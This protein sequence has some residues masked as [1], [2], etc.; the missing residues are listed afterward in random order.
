MEHSWIFLCTPPG[1]LSTRGWIRRV[2]SQRMGLTSVNVQWAIKIRLL[3][4]TVSLGTVSLTYRSSDLP[5]RSGTHFVNYYSCRAASVRNGRGRQARVLERGKDIW[6]AAFLFYL[7]KNTT[8]GALPFPWW[9]EWDF[10][11]LHKMFLYFLNRVRRK[12]Y[13]LLNGFPFC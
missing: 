10:T 7:S 6:S 11:E 9:R 12:I 1:A 8:Q 4:Q 2:L 13:I 5:W 3:L